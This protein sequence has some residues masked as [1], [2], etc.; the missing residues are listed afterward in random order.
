MNGDRCGDFT[1]DNLGRKSIVASTWNTTKS[2]ATLAEAILSCW[3]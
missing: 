3:K 1:M 2:G